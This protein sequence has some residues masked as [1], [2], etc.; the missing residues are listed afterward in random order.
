MPRLLALLL[1]LLACSADAAPTTAPRS[2]PRIVAIGGVITEVLFALGQGS[3]IVGVDTSS[4]YPLKAQKLPQVGSHHAVS[5][6]GV[7]SLRP[8]LVL[9]SAK[10]PATL[11]QQLQATGVSVA[12]I[13][14]IESTAQ[15]GDRIQHIA[16]AAN[17]GSAGEELASRVQQTIVDAMAE[18]PPS[19]VKVL[20]V[21]ARGSRILSVAGADTAADS[22]IQAAGF[23]NAASA[24]SGFRP[25]NAEAVVAAQPDVLLMMSSGASSL[26]SQGGAFSLPG[27]AL[28]PAGKNQRLVQMDGLFMLGLGPRTGQAIAAL[29][30]EVSNAM[31]QEP[32]L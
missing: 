16:D 2:G 11:V 25:L 14:E 13:R 10:T 29:R 8:T 1:A 3:S 31:K 7:L 12:T 24:V 6:E 30:Q 20:F 22:I 5:V 19:D 15:V 28:T 17:L 26:V 4:T 21:Y 18:S 9:A 32:I 23:A 27:M